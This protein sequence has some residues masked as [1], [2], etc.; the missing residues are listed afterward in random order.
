MKLCNQFILAFTV[1][2][3]HALHPANA[4]DDSYGSALVDEV[5]SIYDGDTF[6]VTIKDWPTIIGQRIPVRINGI[7]TPEL[8]GKCQAEKKL[9][10]KAK[11]LTVSILR[12]ANKIELKNIKRGKYFRIVADVLINGENLGGSLLRNNL[13]VKYKGGT[14]INWCK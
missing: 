10:R 7:D 2:S 11:Q 14:K 12:T 1:L 5:T 4:S 8:R 9:A 3:L 6:R 13:A